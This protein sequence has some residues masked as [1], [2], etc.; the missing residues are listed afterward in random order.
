[1]T[2]DE[3]GNKRR[4]V[5]KYDACTDDQLKTLI[6]H[7]FFTI[8]NG[9][10]RIVVATCAFGMGI[11]CP[12]VYRVFHW[13]LPST[14]AMYVQEV[15]RCGRDGH[16]AVATLLRVGSTRNADG[17]I[18]AYGQQTNTCRRKM[19][20]APFSVAGE[21]AMGIHCDV[22]HNCCDIYEK[23]CKCTSCVVICTEKPLPQP[24]P[25]AS[26]SRPHLM[27]DK[28]KKLHDIFLYRITKVCGSVQSRNCLSIASLSLSTIELLSAITDKMIETIVNKHTTIY[29]INDI[30]LISPS[31]SHVDPAAMVDMIDSCYE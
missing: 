17:D 1:M 25:F 7:S 29:T 12:N 9:V 11:D 8:P 6:L 31:L 30:K 5:E 2:Q 4:L 21:N 14:V 23:T 13:G 3:D 27:P 22:L 26:N 10:V 28:L 18:I 19:L 15:G 16:N 24:V 20:M